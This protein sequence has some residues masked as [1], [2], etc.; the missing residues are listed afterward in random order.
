MGVCEKVPLSYIGGFPKKIN[1]QSRQ[2]FCF[3]AVYGRIQTTFWGQ[4]T[5][6]GVV[7]RGQKWFYIMKGIKYGREQQEE[8]N[9]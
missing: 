3:F 4:I 2:C 5:F 6:I 1:G 8:Q 7:A 9:Y